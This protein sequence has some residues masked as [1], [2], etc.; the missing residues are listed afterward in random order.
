[1]AIEVR[2]VT[3]HLTSRRC[4]E[5]TRAPRRSSMK[6]GARSSKINHSSAR[7]AGIARF[8]D[9]ERAVQ[10]APGFSNV[11][12]P[13]AGQVDS[14]GCSG[15]WSCCW[16]RAASVASMARLTLT[17]GLG[18]ANRL[19]DSRWRSCS[20]KCVVDDAIRMAYGRRMPEISEQP[21]DLFE[22]STNRRSVAVP[23]TTLENAEKPA[24]IW[25]V[26]SVASALSCTVSAAANRT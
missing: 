25:N 12:P 9:H 3:N 2:I 7:R 17:A 16:G 22:R 24:K 10:A 26:G 23:P 5:S 1:M 6:E 15:C 11:G 19:Q 8:A 13:Q 14:G 20:S 4:H 21:W 18:R